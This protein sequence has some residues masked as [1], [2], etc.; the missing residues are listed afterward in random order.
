MR[1]K[2]TYYNRAVSLAE[3][4]EKLI[5]NGKAPT[6]VQALKILE[7]AMMQESIEVLENIDLHLDEIHKDL[8]QLVMD[9]Q[10]R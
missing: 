8:F 6:I 5:K 7:L 3:T 10:D 4:A 2:R 1:T 9:G